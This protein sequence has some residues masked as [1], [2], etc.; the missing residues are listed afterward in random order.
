MRFL[1]VLFLLLRKQEQSKLGALILL[2]CAGLYLSSAIIPRFTLTLVDKKLISSFRCFSRFHRLFVHPLFPKSCTL[3]DSF[4]FSCFPL[5]V[6]L[7]F[8]A[9]LVL[10]FIF[11]SHSSP[12]LFE[13]K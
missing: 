5:R 12:C 8:Q 7:F 13:K 10:L 6:L 3:F 2:L 4:C 9:F 11:R 1:A